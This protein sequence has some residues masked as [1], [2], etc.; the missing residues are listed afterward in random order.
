MR[1]ESSELELSDHMDIITW[2]KIA[3]PGSELAVTR[4]QSEEVVVYRVY[5]RRWFG[6][7]VLMLLNIVVS[8]G[9]SGGLS[10]AKYSG[11]VN[12]DV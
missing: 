8:W 11:R 1:T 3:G 4:T 6:L 7:V 9:V 5:K 2:Q 12:T 10:S